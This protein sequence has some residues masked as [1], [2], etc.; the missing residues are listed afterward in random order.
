MIIVMTFCFCLIN[1]VSFPSSV[2]NSSLNLSFSFP[3]SVQAEIRR[4]LDDVI[5]GVQHNAPKE[6]SD[7]C[8]MLLADANLI[9][10][11]RDGRKELDDAV[12][13]LKNALKVGGRRYLF[14]YILIHV[15]KYVERK[16]DNATKQMPP[17]SL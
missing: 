15:Y 13:R 8:R 2:A 12:E 17:L 4:H 3:R 11:K 9:D 7:A 1:D 14:T 16:R 10:N 5:R 6:V